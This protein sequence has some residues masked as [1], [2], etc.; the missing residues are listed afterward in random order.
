MVIYP[1]GHLSTRSSKFDLRSLAIR[2]STFHPLILKSTHVAIH[3]F[4][5]PIIH[6]ST[7]MSIHPSA[8]LFSRSSKFDLQSLAI[9]L[10]PLLSTYPEIYPRCRSLI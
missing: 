5:H 7:H 1:P 10:S 2:L 3:L 4:S 9:R 6:L 8:H